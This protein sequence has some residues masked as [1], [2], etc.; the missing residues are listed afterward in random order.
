[1]KHSPTT[2][3]QNLPKLGDLYQLG[4]HRLLCGDA[5]NAEHIKKLFGKEKATLTLVDVPYG[6]GYVESKAGFKQK[7]GKDKIIAN[8]HLQSEAEYRQFT[9]EWLETIKPYLKPKNAYYIF[10]SDKM[11]FALRE[12]LLEAD[13]HFSQLLI[14]IKNNVVVGRMDYL[15]QHELIAYGWYGRHEFRKSKD[16]S[17]LTYPKPS[18]SKLHPTMKPIGL[19]RRLILNSTKVGDVVY[20]GFGGSGSTLIACEQTRRRCLMVEID[21]EYCQVIIDR[22]EKVIGIKAKKLT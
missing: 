14:W 8:D 15:P 21:P 18:K 5:K 19:L 22:F 3:L 16:K 4:S 11:L 20:D 13:Y 7:L 17:I 12:G 1:M 2:K 9:K 6:V 10:N